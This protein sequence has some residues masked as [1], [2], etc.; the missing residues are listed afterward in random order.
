MAKTAWRSVDDYIAA[1]PESVQPVLRRVRHAIR[2]ALPRAVE[3]ISYQ[4]PVYRVGGRAVIY[5]AGWKAHYSLYP[6]TRGLAAD[7]AADLAP[8]RVSK[9]TL[10][11]PLDEPV[12]IQLIMRI[13]KLRARDEAGGAGDDTATQPR[14]GRRSA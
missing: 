13:A 11:F 6:V 1:Q 5:F 2:R 10:R 7:L 4:I 9:G 3:G 8:Y 12:P 14:T